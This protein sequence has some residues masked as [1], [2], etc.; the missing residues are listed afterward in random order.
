MCPLLLPTTFDHR[1]I[2]FRFRDRF[3]RSKW[4][5]A[6]NALPR[7]TPD[8]SARDLDNFYAPR[9]RQGT[10]PFGGL[11][12]F[13]RG[14]PQLFLAPVLCKTVWRSLLTRNSGEE[15]HLMTLPSFS[16]FYCLLNINLDFFFISLPFLRTF[17]IEA[18][19]L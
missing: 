12:T 1:S 14:A 17:H 5:S 10:F 7:Q 9:S 8:L 11:I 4:V 18:A 15:R 16:P 13:R 2:N 3:T 19:R 6:S